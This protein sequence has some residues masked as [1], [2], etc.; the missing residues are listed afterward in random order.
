MHFKNFILLLLVSL[1]YHC[2]TEAE[3]DVLIQNGT[4]YDGTGAPPTRER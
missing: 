2:S 4:L 1:F 3:V